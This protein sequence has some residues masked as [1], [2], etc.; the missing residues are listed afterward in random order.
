MTLGCSHGQHHYP[1]TLARQADNKFCL[2]NINL[3]CRGIYPANSS[4]IAYLL[5]FTSQTQ[6]ERCSKLTFR[7]TVGIPDP[8]TL[9]IILEKAGKPGSGLICASPFPCVCSSSS[10]VLVIHAST[11]LRP[12]P[13]IA[14]YSI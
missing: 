1:E 4:E 9:L 11:G 14:L 6:R 7:V 3:E 5:K 13:F 12:R 2:E 10:Y 8:V